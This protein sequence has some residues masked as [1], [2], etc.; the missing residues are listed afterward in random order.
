[1]QVTHDVFKI[2]LVDDD[3]SSLEVL[4][5]VFQSDYKDF[6][7]AQLNC[8]IIAAKSGEAGLRR[9]MNDK[10]DLIL[11]DIIM[12]GMSGFEV[13]TAL[14]ESEST[15]S[16]PVI[17]ITGLGSI[18][19]EEKGFHLG[20]VDFITKP[21]H[22]SL[23]KARVMTHLRIVE[24]IRIIEQLGLLDYLT[25]MPN[26]RG[27][28]SRMAMEWA[29]AIR[30][31]NPISFCIIDVDNFKTVNDTYGHKQGDI[32]L[33]LIADIIKSS[34]ERPADLAARWGGD[35]FALL[36][37]GTD[38]SGALA[39]A[40]GIRLNVEQSFIQG[41]ALDVNMTISIGIAATVPS[42]ESSTVDLLEQ[43]DKALYAAKQA[44]RNR[45]CA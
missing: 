17:I 1:M 15:R 16:I 34:M 6:G 2:L 42:V 44:G 14:K 29:R 31:K 7:D 21:F 25:N 32:A 33:K 9:A 22:K 37:P 23:V 24:Q 12:P 13:L 5:R 18:E 3:R 4:S 41:C 10:P 45:V 39:V 30:E 8:R 26:R 43:A 38:I 35:E 27:L 19:D 11:L 36:L 40:E 28:D 20:A